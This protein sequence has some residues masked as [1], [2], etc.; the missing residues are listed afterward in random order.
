MKF[1]I[2]QTVKIRT[3]DYISSKVH[4]REGTII[5]QDDK[6]ICPCCDR[7]APNL[8]LFP[9]G[10]FWTPDEIIEAIPTN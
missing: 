4:G 9:G 10:V 2:G 7:P 8:I 6:T 5:G 3:L 1:K